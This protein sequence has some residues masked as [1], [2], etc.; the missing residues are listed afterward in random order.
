MRSPIHGVCCI[1]RVLLIRGVCTYLAGD[2]F[3]FGLGPGEEAVANPGL[4]LPAL[5]NLEKVYIRR[6]ILAG[7]LG[8]CDRNSAL[9]LVYSMLAVNE[10]PV[11]D[12]LF[13]SSARSGA[14]GT[15]AQ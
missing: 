14:T 1:S 4:L 10:S 13:F 15:K 8:L 5:V 7:W 2:P 3:P 12:G 6:Q 11:P 9:V